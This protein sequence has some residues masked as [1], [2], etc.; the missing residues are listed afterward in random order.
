MSAAGQNLLLNTPPSLR[1]RW[2]NRPDLFFREVLGITPWSRQYDVLRAYTQYNRVATRSGHKVSKS[3]SVAGIALHWV[4]TRERGRVA[5]TSST[6]LQ[7]KKI[8]WYE[9]N[10]MRTKA[11]VGLGGNWHN[12]PQSGYLFNDG[13]EIFGFST[14]KPEKAAGISGDQ[15][16]Y[17][18]DE[19]SGELER[20]I[21][22][23]EGNLAGGGKILLFGN[24]TRTSGEFF[25]AFHT[26]R[27]FWHT[28]K[29]ASFE[30]PNY[31]HRKKVIPGLAT[32]EWVEERR[33]MWG[34]DSPIWSVRVGGDFPRQSDMAIIPL[35]LVEQ[36]QRIYDPHTL[37][38]GPLVL[39]VDVSY[40]GSDKSVIQPIKGL[41]MFKPIEINLFNDGP[42]LGGRVHEAI[43][44]FRAAGIVDPKSKI[45]VNVDIIGWG[46]SCYDFLNHSEKKNVLG[47]IVN[48][49][50]VSETSD[51]P[52]EY[53]NTRAQLTFGIAEWLRSGGELYPHDGLAGELVSP[54]YSFDNKGRYKM[55]FTKLEEAKPENLGHSPDNRDALMLGIYN[56]TR[57]VSFES[58]GRRLH[59]TR[60]MH[61]FV[62]GN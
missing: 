9:L 24:P 45:I 10:R 21:D 1:N 31:H 23:I 17:L 2:F 58:R 56:P 4:A 13:R 27:A 43:R 11:R 34:E 40:R 50:N 26:K 59:T 60:Q 3:N 19:A 47:Y 38:V 46:A 8:I 54:D 42:E 33:A 41:K 51:E 29:I 35:W 48:G 32:Y 36:A 18:I 61:D 53:V 37:G 49:I 52:D 16:L 5:I 30:T 25:N 28:I 15:I 7:V 20:T 39:G 6:Y 44:E 12:D 55:R 22:A 57:P 14:D 62:H